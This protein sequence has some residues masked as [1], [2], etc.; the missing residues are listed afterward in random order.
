MR[1]LM[2][3]PDYIHIAKEINP[4]MDHEKQPD[5]SRARKQWQEILRRYL[6]LGVE[7]W[8]IEPQPGLQDMC[9]TANAGWCRWGKIVLANF[10]DPDV[11]EVRQPE[12]RYYTEWFRTYR[13]R[14]LGVEIVP[15]PF[16]YKGFEGQGD[17][18]TV[19]KGKRDSLVLVGYGQGRTDYEA[20]EVLANIH[21]LD[22]NQVIPMRLANELFYHLDTACLFIPPTTFLY[23][24]EAFDAAGRRIIETLPVDRISVSEDDAKRF[25]CNGVFVQGGPETTILMNRPS[26]KL[27][28]Q[29]RNRGFRVCSVNMEEFQKSG[30]SVRCLTLFLPEE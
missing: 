5:V 19:G 29:L 9:F 10:I 16:R 12:I 21:R 23:Y 11:A 28:D 7:V 27:Q 24:P 13:E 18:V 22:R 4:W 15:F 2:C 25:V 26:R 17:V 20:A 8:F 30:G 1:A 3:P 6:N 14:L